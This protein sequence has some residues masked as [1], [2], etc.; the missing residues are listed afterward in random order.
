MIRSASFRIFNLE[1]PLYDGYCPIVKDGP[2][3]SAPTSA[4]KGL[5]QMGFDLATIGNNHILDHGQLG[6]ESTICTLTDCNIDY[7]GAVI[8]K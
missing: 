7:V 5:K 4:I 3:L 2:N 1:T 6:L 8:T